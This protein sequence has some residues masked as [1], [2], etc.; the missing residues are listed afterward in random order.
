MSAKRW[1]WMATIVA[2]LALA[3]GVAAP[4]P[5]QEADAGAG[6]PMLLPV[7]ADPLEVATA[8]GP[9]LFTIEVADDGA[10]RSAGLMYRRT[11]PDDRGMLFIFEETRPVSFWM[12]NTPMPLD[13]VF[14]AEQGRIEAILP[15]EPY[16]IAPV[17]PGKPV[18]YV[19]ELKAGTAAREGI[20]VGDMVR[21][22]RMGQTG[23]SQM[24]PG[25]GG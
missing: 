13:L 22:P 5:A 12:K 7:D 6:Q 17:S 11:M 23:T 21:H 16:S 10:R 4:L 19:L 18:R 20:S 15:G 1:S 9:R 2:C 14:I 3:A 8:D 25:S 24:A